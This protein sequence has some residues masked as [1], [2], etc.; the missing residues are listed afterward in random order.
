MPLR[1]FC[2][3]RT[4]ILSVY[5]FPLSIVWMLT[6]P[7][8]KL[9][10]LSVGIRCISRAHER[11]FMLHPK[12]KKLPPLY[13]SEISVACLRNIQY[14]YNIAGPHYRIHLNLL[15]AVNAFEYKRKLNIRCKGSWTPDPRFRELACASPLINTDMGDRSFTYI[16]CTMW[17]LASV[18][19]KFY[20]N[21]SQRAIVTLRVM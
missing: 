8:G 10:M 2:M 20:D 13:V 9:K 12:R 15:L 16:T 7:N 3:Q 19:G 6:M 21:F 11:V 18:Q 5:I 14:T 17:W 1:Q 4:E